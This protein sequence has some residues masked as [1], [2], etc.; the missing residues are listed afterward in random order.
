VVVNKINRMGEYLWGE[1]GITLDDSIGSYNSWLNTEIA[2][3]Q[4]IVFVWTKTVDTADQVYTQR[5]LDN[6]TP[7]WA[8][9]VQVS[10]APGSREAYLLIKSDNNA[11][12]Y[13]WNDH[14]IIGDNDWFAQKLD[15]TGQQLWN[16]NDIPITYKK[17]SRI[18]ILSDGQE[19]AIIAWSDDEP[20]NG[21]FIQQISKNGILGEVIT[22]LTETFNDNPTDNYLFQNYPNPFNSITK[23]KYQIHIEQYVTLTVYDVLGKKVSTLYNEEKPAGSYEIEFDGAELTSGVY[24]YTIT[25]GDFRQTKKLLYLK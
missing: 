8:N 1:E 5:L 25:A 3:N 18:K 21:I 22:S 13:V 10:S 17:P 9:P 2:D 15:L 12:I 23:I 4:D 24:F 14:R 20:F 16:S 11:I 6:G 7:R 19:G